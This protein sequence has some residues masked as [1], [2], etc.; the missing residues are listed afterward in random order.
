M[1]EIRL[2]AFADE[3]SPELSGQIA[4]MARN[5]I[6]LLEIRG[7]GGK[8]FPDLTLSEIRE[9]KSRLEDAGM[10]VFSM[11]SP[12]GKMKPESSFD[13]HLSVLGRV[14]EYADI[15]GCSHIRM[16]SFYEEPDKSPEE[17]RDLVFTRM[18]AFL[19]RTP[20]GMLLCHENE[21]HIYG[22]TPER[23]L[24]LLRAFPRLRAV[25]DP[26]NFVQCGI[27]TLRAWELLSPYV[28][29]MH[30]KDAD[31]QGNIVPC[32]RGLGHFAEILPQYFQKGG[33]V[34]TLEPHL[35]AFVG[36]GALEAGGESVKG[37]IYKDNN[38]AFDAAADAL[39]SVLADVR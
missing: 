4:A 14:L 11:G 33:S 24:E 37:M 26:A 5:G 18:Q 29:Y 6:R 12:L 8:S 34:L 19:D 38:A 1:K 30:V 17:N 28:E 13:D 36:L 32:G 10:Q 21:K 16:F 2:C 39:K 7:V 3:A 9:V 35:A 22:E 15:F 27:D 31:T 23:C 25:F 20:E